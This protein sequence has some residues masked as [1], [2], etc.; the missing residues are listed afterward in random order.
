MTPPPI[1]DCGLWIADWPTHGRGVD[2]VADDAL[3]IRNPQ[4]TIRN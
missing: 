4:S 3:S 2:Q 1:A